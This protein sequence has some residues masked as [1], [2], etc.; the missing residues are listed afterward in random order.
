M[1]GRYLIK[2]KYVWQ[3]VQFYIKKKKNQVAKTLTV[4]KNKMK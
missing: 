4:E 2:K 1:A 3:M